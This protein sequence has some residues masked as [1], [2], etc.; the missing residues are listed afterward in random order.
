MS[1]TYVTTL[2]VGVKFTHVETKKYEEFDWEINKTL[3]EPYQ[4]VHVL[5]TDTYLL[6][7]GVSCEGDDNYVSL[8][9]VDDAVNKAKLESILSEYP[10]YYDVKSYGSYAAL[11][12]Y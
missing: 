8:L 4:C 2:I 12:S 10:R 6:G 7:I 11:S 1:T 3:N 9:D 5:G